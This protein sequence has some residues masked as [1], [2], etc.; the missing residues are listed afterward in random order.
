MFSQ[1]DQVE[2]PRM[3]EDVNREYGTEQ[4]K[5]PWLCFIVVERNHHRRVFRRDKEGRDGNGY[6]GILARKILMSAS[7][8]IQYVRK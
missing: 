3:A 6:P 2:I 8:L 7:L 1:V 5:W 4:A